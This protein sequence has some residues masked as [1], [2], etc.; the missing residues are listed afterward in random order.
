M[1]NKNANNALDNVR[2]DDEVWS[3]KQTA[4]FLHISMPTLYKLEKMGGLPVVPVGVRRKIVL[5]SA[6]MNWVENGGAA[7]G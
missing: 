7:R 6:L 5:R 1:A 2:R 4:D 3:L